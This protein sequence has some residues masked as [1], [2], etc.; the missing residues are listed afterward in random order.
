MN[1]VSRRLLPPMGSLQCFEAAARAENFSRAGDEV[2]LT[3]SAV[4]RQIALLEDRL[5]TEL[6]E[7]V[8]RGVTLTAAGREYLDA[9]TPALARI[10]QASAAMLE[11]RQDNV[12]TIATLPSFG[13]RWLAPRLAKFSAR[14]PDI[15]VNF[16][17]RS[18]PFDLTAAGYDGAVHFG[19]ADWP[20]ADHCLL[21]REVVVPVAAP[22]FISERGIR[23]PGDL[24]KVPL[25]SQQSRRSAW[26]DWF[27]AAG[28][29]LER[30]VSAPAIEHFLMLA[31]AAAAGA[32]IALIPKFLIEPELAS[33]ALAIPFDIELTS[34]D[35]YY[36]VSADTKPSPALTAFREWIEEEGAV[37]A[38]RDLDGSR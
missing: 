3:Q 26:N 37:T 9:I 1:D 30:P 21:F 32:G 33:G 31:Q 14:H 19:P 11:R 16:T 22:S 8:G 13:M 29:T 5:Q 12:L 34:A 27:K 4:S 35:A 2:G 38:T 17:A 23:E 24:Q 15:L 7:R 28:V 6:F 18:V 25:L 20:N 10:R 36:F